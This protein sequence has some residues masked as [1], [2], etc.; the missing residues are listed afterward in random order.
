MTVCTANITLRDLGGDH[1]PGPCQEEY[2]DLP[3]LTRG[4][5][6]VELQRD[7]VGLPAVDTRVGS[8]VV[9]YALSILDP[10]TTNALDLASD[11]LGTISQVMLAT[12][13]GMT[14]TAMR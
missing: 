3:A 4:I 8:Q 7:Y 2:S 13:G 1:T 9:A 6:V 14:R 5:A 10:T 12:V 11:V